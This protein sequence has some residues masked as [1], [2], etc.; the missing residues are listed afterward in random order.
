MLF[1]Q[2]NLGDLKH[3]TCFIDS[4][5]LTMVPLINNQQFNRSIN[6]QTIGKEP[7]ASIPSFEKFDQT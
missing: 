7:I 4:A 1:I 2:S 6:F 5:F 3:G